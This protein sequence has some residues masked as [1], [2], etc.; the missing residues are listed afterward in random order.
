M[1]LYQLKQ[2][3][4]SAEVFQYFP[5]PPWITSIISTILTKALPAKIQMCY[6]HKTF[7]YIKL[8]LTCISSPLI[9]TEPPSAPHPP[10]YKISQIQARLQMNLIYFDILKLTFY[11][12]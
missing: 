8:L 4:E 12:N 11:N 9:S 1:A 3:K 10:D 2:T 5:P 6:A 7:V